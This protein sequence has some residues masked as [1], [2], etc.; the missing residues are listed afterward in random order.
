MPLKLV[1]TPDSFLSLA[2]FCDWGKENY[3]IQLRRRETEGLGAERIVY[4][5]SKNYIKNLS[6]S[7]PSLFSV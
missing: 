1:R 2:P 6:F 7:Q 3:R 4:Y 5:G